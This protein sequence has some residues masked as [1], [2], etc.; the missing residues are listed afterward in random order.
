MAGARRSAQCWLKNRLKHTSRLRW[1]RYDAVGEEKTSADNG[2]KAMITR[3]DED[4]LC[5]YFEFQV[6]R[7]D[8]NNAQWILVN[9]SSTPG[10]E[11][12]ATKIVAHSKASV[13]LGNNLSM[14]HLHTGC[15][16]SCVLAWQKHN[17]QWDDLW[18]TPVLVQQ[19]HD[20]HCKIP[21]MV[22]AT[23]LNAKSWLEEAEDTTVT[24]NDLQKKSKINARLSVSEAE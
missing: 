5:I 9:E 4:A 24:R 16:I 2:C 20:D 6:G 13:M 8:K 11:T 22:P 17:A 23:R 1:R 15:L 19:N 14:S 21:N 18:Y 10:L 3:Q 12:A 7:V